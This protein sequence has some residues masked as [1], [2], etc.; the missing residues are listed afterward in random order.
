MNLA[1]TL[2]WSHAPPP[3]LHPQPGGWLERCDL[4]W[5]RLFA[6]SIRGGSAPAAGAANHDEDSALIRR[7]QDGDHAAFEALFRRHA[8]AV[9]RKLT[10][11]LGP[12]P[13]REDLVQEVFLA[14]YRGLQGFR[15]EAAFS[16]WLYRIV[17]RVAFAHMGRRR[18]RPQPTR[19]ELDE[20]DIPVEPRATP[21]ARAAQ[22]QEL[23][24]VF[25][26][27]ERIKPNKRIAFVLRVVE[28]RSLD[29]IG[30]L[31]GATPA[32]VGQRVKHA[33]KELSALIARRR[34]RQLGRGALA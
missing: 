23:V 18:K 27:L 13:E 4:G 6:V 8:D 21:E 11:M 9:Y 16:T 5:L 33:H 1:A 26:H 32:A 12:D 2:A 3:A 28:G 25:E 29:E 14:A 34:Q 30:Q 24:E 31:V 7:S 17:V 20:A 15:G 19:F 10:R 22:R